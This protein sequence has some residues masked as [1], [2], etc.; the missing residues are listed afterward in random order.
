MLKETDFQGFPLDTLRI[1]AWQLLT[2][3]NLLSMP[4][5]RVIHSDL[6]PENIMLK[7]LDRAGVKIIDFGSSSKGTEIQFKCA[8][9]RYYR[10]PEVLLGLPYNNRIDVWSLAC[11]LVEMHTGRPLFPGSNSYD[12]MRKIVNLRGF[13]T[14]N[15]I[16][17]SQKASQY[18][19][20]ADKVT[21]LEPNNPKNSKPTSIG[22]FIKKYGLWHE[23]YIAMQSFL[24]LIDKMLQIEPNKRISAQEALR[25]PFFFTMY[26]ALIKPVILSPKPALKSISPDSEFSSPFSK[27]STAPSSNFSQD[28]GM[29]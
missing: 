25:H 28:E 12:Q 11:I 1:F 2:G 24:D 9:S 22:E 18:F 20:I 15:M 6:K 8:Q 3:L 7:T 27:K 13:P 26:P 16:R 19:N 29:M 23:D 14:L 17:N 4:N 21:M 10:A 5:L